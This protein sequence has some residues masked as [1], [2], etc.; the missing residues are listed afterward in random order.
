MKI[1]A[2]SVASLALALA[3]ALGATPASAD[4]PVSGNINVTTKWTTLGSPYVLSSDVTVTAGVTLTIDPGVVVKANATGGTGGSDGARI[5]L[6][7][8]GTLV[9]DGSSGSTILFTSAKAPQAPGDWF[10]IVFQSTSTGSI[11]KNVELAY[12][13]RPID[14]ESVPAAALTMDKLYIHH[15]TEYGAYFN[16]AATTAGMTNSEIHQQGVASPNTCLYLNTAGAGTFTGLKLHHC[17]YGAYISETSTT[18]QDSLVWG[19]TSRGFYHY[20]GGSTVRIL[21]LKNSTVYGNGAYAFEFYTYATSSLLQAQITDTVIAGHTS[22]AFYASGYYSSSYYP[23]VSYQ[24]SD[25]WNNGAVLS[26]VTASSTTGSI[27]ENPLLVDAASGDFRPTE[28]S[29]LRFSDSTVT[30]PK[31]TIGLYD[32]DGAPTAGY[33]GVYWTNYTFPA[34]NLP[35]EGDITVAKGATVTVPAG[36]TLTMATTDA[37]K[38]G[39]DTARIELIVKGT[40]VTGGTPTSQVVLTSTGTGKTDWYG[41]RVVSGAEGLSMTGTKVAHASRGLSLDSVNL[42]PTD[43]EADTCDTGL[44]LNASSSVMTSL[45]VHDSTTGISVTNGNPQFTGVTAYNNGTG[46]SLTQ[47][48]A[49]F[50]DLVLY[51]NTSYGM[52]I[53]E[54]GS[55]FTNAIKHCKV[56]DNQVGFYAYDYSYPVQVTLDHCTVAFNKSDAFQLYRGYTLALTLTLTATTVTNNAGYAFYGTYGYSTSYLPTATWTYSDVWKNTNG[57]STS[58]TVNASTGSLIYVSAR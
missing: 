20:R 50:Q 3:C 47:T 36:T 49:D 54:G 1:N 42:A 22:G 31:G 10:G 35:I 16:G 13:R 7:I 32:Y 4:T 39:A 2:V 26:Y 29:P 18:I 9:A 37:M 21:T 41:V 46:I 28:R 33:Q 19:N 5:E 14:V 15:F 45:T 52:Y 56:Y 51:G 27:V 58:T 48:Q 34:G 55:G 44:W 30:P 53:S 57:L 8:A 43:L 23:Q 12:A 38:G 6:I 11:V 25:V 17:S 40:L 24:Y